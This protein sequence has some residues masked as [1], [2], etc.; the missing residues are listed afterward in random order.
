MLNSEKKRELTSKSSCIWMMWNIFFLLTFFLLLVLASAMPVSYWSGRFNPTAYNPLSNILWAIYTLPAAVI[1]CVLYN[2]ILLVRQKKL[3]LIGNCM[4]I[5]VALSLVFVFQLAAPKTF[6]YG[7]REFLKN[8]TSIIVIQGW[9]RELD[10]NM[11]PH[12]NGKEWPKAI[13]DLNPSCIKLDRDFQGN[14]KVRLLWITGPEGR[15][16]V[17]VS[18]STGLFPDNGDPNSSI[19]S[20]GYRAKGEFRLIVT[21]GAYVWYE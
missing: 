13:S 10:H 5:S 8:R 16:G 11:D 15:Y 6:T 12:I 7:F 14:Y 19:P 20:E 17:D 1:L 21:P 4:I 18:N 9:L 2:I 3:L